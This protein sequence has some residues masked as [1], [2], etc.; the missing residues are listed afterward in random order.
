MK[1]LEIA[2][3]A[4][5]RFQHPTKPYSEVELNVRVRAALEPTDDLTERTIELQTQADKM[6]SDHVRRF[7]ATCK[8]DAE[9][10]H[11][12]RRKA[13]HEYLTGEKHG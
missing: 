11:E 4:S 6:L 3:A 12:E 8:Q 9:R 13:Y 2:V 5:Q 7:I 10:L 1:P